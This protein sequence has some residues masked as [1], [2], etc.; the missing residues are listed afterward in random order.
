LAAR[1][2]SRI[3]CQPC[4]DWTER[5]YH[6]KGL[7]G[8]AILDRLLELAWF[9]RVAGTRALRLTPA[10]RAGLLHMFG[11]ELSEKPGIGEQ[12]ASRTGRHNSAVM[13]LYVPDGQPLITLTISRIV[14]RRIRG[15]D[16]LRLVAPIGVPGY[17]PPKEGH[18]DDI[19][20][21]DMS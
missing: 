12:A 17:S 15:R 14:E 18:P 4:L 2:R 20:P 21:E 5:R 7:V 3:F 10:G 13:F 11:I 19:R 16:V 8:A 1:A 9:E 6:L